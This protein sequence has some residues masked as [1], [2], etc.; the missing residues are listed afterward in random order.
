MSNHPNRKRL[1]PREL[2]AKMAEAE[3]KLS[4]QVFIAPVMAGRRVR[5][6]VLGLVYEMEVEDKSFAGWAL[7]KMVAAGRA[8][9]VDTPSA[10]QVG[11][12]LKLLPRVRM[13]LLESHDGLW[14]ALSAQRSGSGFTIEK[15]VPVQL[16]ARAGS[17]DTIYA[18]FDGASFWFEEL[19]RRRDPAVARTL[20]QHLENDLKP[21]DLRARGM[22]PAERD[23]Y[24]IAWL[25]RHPEALAS[26]EQIRAESESERL[27]RALRHAGAS[28]D[29]YWQT[30]AGAITVRF[31]VDGVTRVC[32]VRPDD[33]TIMSA[34]ICLSGDDMNFDLA[35]L[36]GVLRESDRQADY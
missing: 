19:D 7:L 10:Q 31:V 32:E 14:W 5:V 33:Y 28:L 9:V 13:V 17:F 34:G 1:D 4:S 35:S 15:P 20:R 29:A 16:V 2:V 36:V 23:A 11:Q 22:V 3:G 21:V 24:T 12:Y 18:R 30:N 6:R 26:P 27:Q 8:A 25:A